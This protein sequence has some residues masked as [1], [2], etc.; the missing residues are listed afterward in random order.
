MHDVKLFKENSEYPSLECHVINDKFF[1]R[2][3]RI[4]QGKYMRGW[5]KCHCTEKAAFHIKILKEVWHVYLIIFDSTSSRKLL[6]YMSN[7][8]INLAYAVL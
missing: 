5:I 8:N 3:Q 2:G 1:G 7:K 4:C 6:K